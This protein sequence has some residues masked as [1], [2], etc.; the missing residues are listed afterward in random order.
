MDVT[1]LIRNRRAVADDLV[2]L[3]TGQVITKSGC[4]IHIPEFY[5]ETPLAHIGV[6]CNIIGIHGIIVGDNYAMRSACA[7]IRTTP[8][9]VSKVKIGE[10]S[11]F[12]LKYDPGSPVYESLDLVKQATL[13]YHIQTVFMTKG[14][15]PWYMS[16]L[17]RGRIYNT[18]GSHAGAPVGKN[19]ETT[20]LQVAIM[21][22]N[23]ENIRQHYRMCL[24]SLADLDKKPPQVVPMR[25]VST[26]VTSSMAKLSGSYMR[27][28]VVSA[29]VRRTERTD[30]LESILRQ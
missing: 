24:T 17:D 14:K 11:Y 18:S 19:R 13:I 27:Q 1:R 10:E 9:S 21:A 23:P 8:T 5:A 6:E 29:L 22:R 7:M 16:Y 2:E 28:G 20:A 4:A 12:E 26:S 25:N 30:S 15:N 3:E